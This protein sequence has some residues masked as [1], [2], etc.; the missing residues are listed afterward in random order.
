MIKK[1]LTTILILG[2]LSSLSL[3]TIAPVKNGRLAPTGWMLVGNFTAISEE[4]DTWYNYINIDHASGLGKPD[5]FEVSSS[6]TLPSSL[7]QTYFK[8]GQPIW[9]EDGRFHISGTGN[10]KDWG[11][12][13]TSLARIDYWAEIDKWTD[14]GRV[15][16]SVTLIKLPRY[17][18]ILYYIDGVNQGSTYL[19]TY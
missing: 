7:I 9:E 14:P 13:R 8:Y 10:W 16:Y 11:G 2:M 6:K 3:A 15:L 4:G 5:K 18:L 12:E 1:L 17:I 19:R